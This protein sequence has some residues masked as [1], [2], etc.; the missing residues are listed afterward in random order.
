ML[1]SP[2]DHTKVTHDVALTA[3]VTPRSTWG[4]LCELSDTAVHYTSACIQMYISMHVCLWARR[5]ACMYASHDMSCDEIRNVMPCHVLPCNDDTVWG[6]NVM[7]C[8]AM[9]KYGW[10]VGGGGVS[11]VGGTFTNYTFHMLMHKLWISEAARVNNTHSHCTFTIVNP[12][13]G[14]FMN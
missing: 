3:K 10:G 7:P 4:Q 1:W 11:Q 5:H 14:S 13:G 2:W 8:H 9:P 12:R 6:V